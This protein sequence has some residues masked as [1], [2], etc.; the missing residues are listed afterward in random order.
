M[1]PEQ[2]T[3]LK[4]VLDNARPILRYWTTNEG[5]G[6]P[7]PRADLPPELVMHQDKLTEYTGDE[8]LTALFLNKHLLSGYFR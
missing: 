6:Y 5:N 7:N 1:T 4:V 3:N 2:K 8:M